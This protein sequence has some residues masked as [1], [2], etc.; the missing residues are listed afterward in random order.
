MFMLKGKRETNCLGD[1]NLI[2]AL[3]KV[4]ELSEFKILLLAEEEVRGIQSTRT[5]HCCCL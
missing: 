3:F 5:M 2:T 4:K 1:A